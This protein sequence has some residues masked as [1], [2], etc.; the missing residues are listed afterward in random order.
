M[1]IL[2]SLHYTTVQLGTPGMKFMVALDTGSDLF[3]VPCEGTAYAPVSCDLFFLQCMSMS[4]MLSG[5]V[6][7]QLL[8]RMSLVIGVRLV[9]FVHSCFCYVKKC[10]LYLVWWRV[11]ILVSCCFAFLK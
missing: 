10:D 9:S 3:W 11:H 2:C 1:G 4:Q 7:F 5:I 8:M 6:K